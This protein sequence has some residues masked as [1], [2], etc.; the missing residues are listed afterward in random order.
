MSSTNPSF[1]TLFEFGKS[2]NITLK[3]S[4][5]PIKDSMHSFF[6]PLDENVDNNASNVSH[7]QDSN[8]ATT[9]ASRNNFY[10]S[11]EPGL[12][13]TSMPV[14]FV[15]GIEGVTSKK[16]S[17]KQ[18]N[19][20][21]RPKSLSKKTA[22]AYDTLSST[23]ATSNMKETSK[24]DSFIFSDPTPVPF[25]QSIHLTPSSI[26]NSSLNQN[27]S[28]KSTTL[29]SEKMVEADRGKVFPAQSSS[30]TIANTPLDSLYHLLNRNSSMDE[31]QSQ[32]QSQPISDATSGTSSI[33][34]TITT[35]KIQTS[36]EAINVHQEKCPP[37]EVLPQSEPMDEDAPTTSSDPEEEESAFG[38]FSDTVSS[39]KYS[40]PIIPTVVP[41][42]VPTVVPAMKFGASKSIFVFSKSPPRTTSPATM[43]SGTASFD[44]SEGGAVGAKEGT[45]GPSQNAMPSAQGSS[46]VQPN[47]E[48]QSNIFFGV[49]KDRYAASESAFEIRQV[50]DIK[51]VPQ[52]T[53]ET[54]LQPP[55]PPATASQSQPLESKVGFDFTSTTSNVSASKKLS[56]KT[57][58]RPRRR[59][60][61]HPPGMRGIS[62]SAS[63]NDLKEVLSRKGVPPAVSTSLSSFASSLGSMGAG[64]K[65]SSVPSS[66]TS[67]S[68]TPNTMSPT[69]P[70]IDFG[71]SPMESSVSEDI[72][73]EVNMLSEGGRRTE[74]AFS[75]PSSESYPQPTPTFNVSS[76]VRSEPPIFSFGGAIPPPMEAS[77][78]SD[79]TDAMDEESNAVNDILRA[80]DA[81]RA[82]ASSTDRSSDSNEKATA[83][84]GS[85]LSK[86]TEDDGDNDDADSSSE[87]DG[88]GMKLPPQVR[89][90]QR[91][92]EETSTERLCQLADLLR[93]QGKDAYAA[94]DYPR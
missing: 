35:D 67:S 45:Q 31:P 32:S 47:I 43:P 25:S 21:P 15:S 44:S 39:R 59:G 83:R 14:F 94:E 40:A 41:A 19:Q 52:Q 65:S 68:T 71:A 90:S 57:L 91:V 12:L 64:A 66:D 75:I 89:V 9:D 54:P 69:S 34:P 42:S 53:Q 30:S 13:S 72:P 29:A 58:S 87:A 24:D 56:S 23:S 82:K 38:P 36:S 79:T 81:G 3:K 27:E 11:K 88:E 10:Q 20:K 6:Y 73:P 7:S 60:A 74:N 51:S 46:A 8:N 2:N 1:P 50:D 76:T 17:Q 16:L 61:I 63:V 18:R 93:K 4:K 22:V 55:P 80:F 62:V 26:S 86:G 92:M 78:E 48:S 85:I 37:E 84:S 77:N 49:T 28:L 70:N 5:S 33:A